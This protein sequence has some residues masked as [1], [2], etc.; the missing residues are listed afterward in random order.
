MKVNLNNARFKLFKE[1]FPILEDA[2]TNFGVDFYVLGALARDMLYSTEDTPSRTTADIDLA[3]YI[4]GGEEKYKAVLDY[5]KDNHDFVQHE[6]NAFSVI[7]A[8]GHTIDLLPFGDIEVEDGVSITGQGLVDIKVNGFREVFEAGLVKLESDEGYNFS[9]ASLAAIVLLKLIA[10]DDRPEQRLKDPGDV[11]SIIHHYF[12]LNEED[13][14]E[15]HSD[16][17]A[18]YDGKEFSLQQ[19]AAEVVGRKIFVLVDSSEILRKRIHS[20]LNQ[21]ISADEKS[22]FI[23]GMVGDKCETVDQAVNWLELVNKGITESAS[24]IL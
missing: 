21:H 4:S 2:L 18:E 22:K 9:V 10:F 6:G 16:L 1:M 3:L 7:S 20:I 11:A 12:E 19:V 14:F 24:D 15:N 8:S 23:R 5:L 17:F 13:I